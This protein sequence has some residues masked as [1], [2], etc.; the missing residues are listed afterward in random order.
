MDEESK[1]WDCIEYLEAEG[2]LIR[3]VKGHRTDVGYGIFCWH[4]KPVTKIFRLQISR[5]FEN[6]DIELF[7][8]TCFNCSNF[9]RT[10]EQTIR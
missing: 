7:H 6:F 9:E 3:P 2:Y 8:R 10:L 1:I 4:H 5:H